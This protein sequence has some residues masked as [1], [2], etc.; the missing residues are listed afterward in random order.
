MISIDS[1]L[2]L[3]AFGVYCHA[4]FVSITLGF[5]VA[6]MALLFRYLKTGEE[7]YF[8]VAKVMTWV[9]ALNFALGAITGTL[10]EFGLVQAW[11]GTILAIA[12]FA[13]V[14]L[15]LELLAFANEIAFLV[16]SS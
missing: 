4:L 2:A 1:L 14:P 7:D 15:A 8:R 16:C 3:S 11:P 12:S 5:P 9:L 13:F 6:I 10:V